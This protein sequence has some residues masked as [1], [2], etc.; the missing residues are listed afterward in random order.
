[1]FI[2]SIFILILLAADL[3]LLLKRNIA[4]TLPVSCFLIILGMYLFSLVN[5]LGAAVWGVG[6]LVVSFT[7]LTGWKTLGSQVRIKLSMTRRWH[8]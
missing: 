2:F 4:V 3:S 7:C 8:S 5:L 1:M 6:L